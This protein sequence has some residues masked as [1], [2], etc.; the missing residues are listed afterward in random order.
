MITKVTGKNMVSIPAELARMF[1]IKPGYSFEWSPSGKPEEI[2]VHVIPD[3]KAQC[4]RLMG[5]GAHFS[6]DRSAVSEL[7]S[8][9]N[10]DPS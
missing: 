9:R 2:I 7:V 5:A 4:F 6:P 8:E 10:Q 3:R 1:Q